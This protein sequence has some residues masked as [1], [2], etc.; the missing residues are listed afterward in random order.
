MDFEKLRLCMVTEQISGR[1]IS[2]PRVLTS[3]RKVQREKFVPAEYGDLSYADS[4]LPIGFGQTISQPLMVA[5][6]IEALRL[7]GK[8]TVLE[9]GTGSGYAAAVLAEIARR[10][11]TIERIEKLADSARDRLNE[12]KYDNVT[13][14]TDNGIIGCEKF[15]PYDAILVS[16]GA[17]KVPQPLR[18][19]LKIGGVLVIPAGPYERFQKLFRITRMAE[20][21]YREEEL[22]DVSFVPLVG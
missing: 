16:A 14:I 5:T 11:I 7:T 4:P 22:C 13:V 17:S 1:G 20:N 19:Q 3:M 6:M 12:L 9:I 15:A 18:L 21:D 2:D 8:E 10:V